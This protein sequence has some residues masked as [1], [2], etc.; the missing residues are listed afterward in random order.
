MLALISL[1]MEKGSR[2]AA[3]DGAVARPILL[4]ERVGHPGLLGQ[5]RNAVCGG[6]PAAERE[7]MDPLPIVPE[8]W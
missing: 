6:A 4:G 2:D 7:A 8:K 5:D 1:G 3:S